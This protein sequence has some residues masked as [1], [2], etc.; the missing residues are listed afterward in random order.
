MP[1][2]LFPQP[3][4]NFKCEPARIS[5]A[6]PRRDARLGLLQ[7]EHE[8]RQVCEPC[9]P[10]LARAKLATESSF[11][12]EELSVL[13]YPV[14]SSV[15][16]RICCR[17]MSLI[18]ASSSPSPSFNCTPLPLPFVGRHPLQRVSLFLADSQDLLS[19]E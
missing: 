8:F 17:C 12:S 2:G 18:A 10:C 14:L 15:K 4:P 9:L 11:L 13:S 16:I 3:N 19:Y 1:L 7:Y 6:P 5:S